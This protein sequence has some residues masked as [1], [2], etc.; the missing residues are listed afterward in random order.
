MVKQT[1]GTGL[2]VRAQDKGEIIPVLVAYSAGIERRDEQLVTVD[3]ETDLG[4]FGKCHAKRDGA[5]LS[6]YHD[7][8]IGSASPHGTYHIGYAQ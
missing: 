3:R 1:Y 8:R 6:G 5:S 7:K 2:G 4:R